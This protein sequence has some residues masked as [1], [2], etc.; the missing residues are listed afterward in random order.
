[1][2]IA[3]GTRLGPYEIVSR[4]GAGGMG[5]VW[6]ARDSRLGRTV[7]IKVLP[8]EFAQD[9]DFCRRFEREARIISRLNHPNICTLHDVG[10][11]YLV[12]E[13]VEGESLA[14]RLRKGPLPIREALRYG[15]EI[16]LALDQAHRA[17]VIHRDLK[18]GNIMVTNTGAK[19]LDFGLARSEATPDAEDK[20]VTAP[21]T[22]TG[23]IV[24]TVPYM[25]PEQLEAKPADARTDIFAL[26]A[27]LYEMITGQRAFQG[28]SRAS[29]I[30][31]ILNTEP[32]PVSTHQPLTPRSL[33]HLMG[34]CLAKNPDERW[35]SAKDLAGQLRWIAESL[36]SES[37]AGAVPASRPQ[38]RRV[39]TVA[40]VLGGLLL[41]GAA[42][43]FVR[44]KTAGDT[45]S[46]QQ[47]PRLVRLTWDMKSRGPSISP[48]GK[49][50]AYEGRVSDDP[51]ANRDIFVKRIGGENATNL[52]KG[53]GVDHSLPTFSPDGQRIAFQMGWPSTGIFVMG[54]TGESLRRVTSSGFR[55]AWSPD[56][57]S[58]AFASLNAEGLAS[59]AVS[60]LWVVD[61]ETGTTRKI[62][63][64][65]AVRPFWSPSGKRVGFDGRRKGMAGERALSTISVTG[66]EPVEVASTP[67]VGWMTGVWSAGWI[68]YINP[69][70]GP[71]GIWRIRVD[72]D[73]GKPLA[74]AEP[75]LRSTQEIGIYFSATPSGSRIVFPAFTRITELLRWDVD[76]STGAVS[77]GPRQILPGHRLMYMPVPSPDRTWVAARLVEQSNEFREDLA[78]VS[79]SSGEFRWLTD[80]VFRESSFDWSPDG[81]WLYFCVALKDGSELW[82]IRPDGSGRERVLAKT[83][84]GE[85]LNILVSRVGKTL[86]VEGGAAHQPFLAER[87]KDGYR[88][89][90]LP[91]MPGERVFSALSW[92]ADGRWFSGRARNPEGK[93]E[94]QLVLFD[95]AGKKYRELDAVKTGKAAAFL[96]DSRRLLMVG[97]A[98]E[99]TVLDIESGVSVPGGSI[100]PDADSVSISRDG[101]A[102]FAKGENRQ[103]DIWMLDFTE[104]PRR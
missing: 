36:S 41:A 8:K 103:G 76:P 24:G 25:A 43:W 50:L 100:L 12:M 69:E 29:L 98:G 42:G 74:S 77:G 33:E 22:E 28:A 17:G 4:I 91:K 65:D 85:V 39:L 99:V 10:E 79:E 9:R 86:Y 26:G 48:D 64:G 71:P 46:P 96:P 60:S 78:L 44:S 58:I 73:T 68:W 56:G 5:E 51:N 14:E 53:S 83:P 13:F 40:S 19:L 32:A 89:E 16:A 37:V 52:T 45:A 35:Q 87:G 1:M 90:P 72:E 31:A 54:A 59:D 20:T 15:A 30:A 57:R 102:L 80:D 97:H 75:V 47:V 62:Y 34:K 67:G 23:A 18:P 27:V 84:A 2:E 101:K 55:P 88:F 7:A 49:T 61:V 104:G 66:G 6:R 63:D 3:P 11:G 94:D 93:L 21:L 81:T 38:S 92:S 70:K 95:V 82:R